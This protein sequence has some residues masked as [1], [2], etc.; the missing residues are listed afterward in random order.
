[1]SKE[2]L[3]DYG[4]ADPRRLYEIFTGGETWISYNEPERKTATCTW[5]GKNDDGSRKPPSKNPGPIGLD[6]RYCI[7]FSLMY[8]DQWLKYAYLKAKE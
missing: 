8:M 5:V 6:G 2:L 7:Q 4:N 1:M 3:K